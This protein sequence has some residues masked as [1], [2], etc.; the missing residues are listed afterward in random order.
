MNCEACLG[1]GTVGPCGHPD[2]TDHE[3]AAC[4]GSGKSEDEQSYRER[5]DTDVSGLDCPERE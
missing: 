2:C 3:C 5:T 1:T 4:A